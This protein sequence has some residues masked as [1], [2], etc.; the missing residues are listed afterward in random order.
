MD[1]N[2]H[3]R[4]YWKSVLILLVFLFVLAACSSGS[5]DSAAES[6][7]LTVKLTDIQGTVQVLKPEAGFF[8]DAY[9][10]QVLK[11]GDQLLTH[12]DSTAKLEFSSGTIVRVTP[13]TTF[14]VSRLENSNNFPTA[15][16]A[17]EVGEVFVI[18]HGGDLT[19]KSQEGSATVQG[20][21]MSVKGRLNKLGTFIICLEGNCRAENRVEIV[22]LIAGQVAEMGGE[23]LPIR[24]GRMS[25]KQ[26]E[27]WLELNPE[28]EEI[29]TAVTETVQA[30]YGTQTSA[31]PAEIEEPTSE[32]TEGPNCG[33]PEGWT[34]H[35]VLEGETIES[36]AQAYGISEAALRMAACLAPDEAGNP[37]QAIFV[38]NLPT[39]TPTASNTPVPPQNTPVPPTKTPV[40]S[41]KTPKITP[42]A[43]N[44]PGPTGTPTTEPTPSDTPT[45][46]STVD[47]NTIFPSASGPLSSGI[48]ICNQTYTVEVSDIDGIQFVKV[49][50][51]VNSTLSAGSPTVILTQ[52]GSIWS[53]TF[54][55]DTSAASSTDTVSWRFWAQDGLGNDAY[56]PAGGNFAYTDSLNCSGVK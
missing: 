2:A 21:Y 5:G 9:L 53:G 10:G 40:P 39:I 55:I 22:D 51:A 3:P 37:G 50:F 30:Y 46:S 48:T 35:V 14:V 29:L 38:P 20:S 49:Q 32:T 28:A 25:P 26:L 36:I 54:A 6:G 15:E 52:N 23:E 19:V 27:R 31:A 33:P 56:H 45:P 41:T 43:S 1:T 12:A 42:T 17:L 34:I 18:L 13:L 4:L 16:L 44:T 47:P 8:A 24:P 11:V 7:G